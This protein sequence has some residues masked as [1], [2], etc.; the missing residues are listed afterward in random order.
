MAA[1]AATVSAAGAS[2]TSVPGPTTG[3]AGAGRDDGRTPIRAS[4]ADTTAASPA[5]RTM[6]M[7]EPGSDR[8]SFGATIMHTA[9]IATAPRAHGTYPQSAPATA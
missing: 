5:T 2:I 3:S 1:S 6:P 9:T 8:W 4:G 7:S